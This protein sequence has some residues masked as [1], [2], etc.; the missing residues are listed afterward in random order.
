M[1]KFGINRII[2]V[3]FLIFIVSPILITVNFKIETP[4]SSRIDLDDDSLSIDISSLPSPNFE[5]LYTKWYNSKI[6]M[7]IVAPNDANFINELI[8]L[9]E[10]KN[11]K[12]V[13]TIILSNFSEYAGADNAEKIRNMIKDYH[14]RENIQWVLLAGDAEE[15]IIPIRYSYNPDTVVVSGQTEYSTW[16]EYYKPTDFY[17]SALSGNWNNDGDGNWGENPENNGNGID[18]IIWIPDVYVGRLPASNANELQIMV[19]KTLKYEINPEPGSWMN[20]MLLAAGVSSFSPAEDE[21]RLTE[22]IWQNYTL[23]N[24]NFTHLVKTTTS[25]TPS[26][27]PE[28]NVLDNLNST[29]FIKGVNEGYSTIIIAGHADPTRITDASG[30]TFYSNTDASSNVNK[31]SLIYGDAC[32][33]SSYDQGDSSIGERLIK[34][35]N[36]GAIGYIGG[37]RVTWYLDYDTELEKLNR[38]NAKLFWKQFFK[39]M[40]FQQ[41]KALYN[42]KVA[43]LESDYFQRGETSIS[44]EWQR[45]N[46]LTYN[47]L[48][49]PEV[50]IYTDIPVSVPNYFVLPIHEGQ[51]VSF[52]VIN[53]KGRITPNARV[54]LTTLDGKYFTAYANKEGIVKFRLPAQSNEKYN[55]TITGHNLIPTYLNFTTIED[56]NF[57][58]LRSIERIPNTPTISD[59]IQ[60]NFEGYDNQSGVESITVLLSQNNFN[61]FESFQV[62]NGVLD[63][64][65]NFTLTLNKLDP[66]EYAYAVAIRDYSNKTRLYY[67]I[68]FSFSIA[69][70]FIE[71]VLIFTLFM[72]VSL[73]GLLSLSYFISLKKKRFKE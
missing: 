50:D 66:G 42:S 64:T 53:N 33:T 11:Q 9:M 47:L 51:L 70:P 13:K 26:L 34:Q 22:Y 21:A 52:S 14:E 5:E 4:I 73:A 17:Y 3:F 45:K 68:A 43:Y 39:E 16:D 7:I 49:D 48:G 18:E 19:N 56:S 31:L 2:Q 36:A 55:V 37:L 1:V 67:D 15:G 6:E 65:Q 20:Q 61:N 71:Y 30:V 59:Q 72:L 41:G 23:N 32:T 12:G 46:I 60:F 35:L 54:H 24:M 25:F 10:W 8:P 58:E 57:P 40:D 38:G 44:L 69:T 63:N 62:S 28:P 29:S 27:P